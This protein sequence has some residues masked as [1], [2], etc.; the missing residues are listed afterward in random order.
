MRIF[1]LFVLALFLFPLVE[2][3]VML[4]TADK[5]T[6]YFPLVVTLVTGVAGVAL[7]R[8]QSIG[9]LRRIQRELA[10]GEVP[11]LSLLHGAALLI[12]GLLL[13]APG[14]VTDAIGLLLLLPPV[15]HVVVT[16]VAARLKHRLE[17]RLAQ[18]AAGPAEE[19]I[20]DVDFSPA[21]PSLPP[22][23]PQ[24]GDAL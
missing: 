23:S 6:W 21:R 12:A 18:F 14:L 3:A 1:L 10:A 22:D 17:V 20:I 13:F 9:N 5:T 4:Y 24:D 7:A 2:L 8:W 16:L 11:A 19:D 15:R